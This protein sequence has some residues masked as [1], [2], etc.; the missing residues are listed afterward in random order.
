MK[1]RIGLLGGT[2]DPVHFGHLRVGEEAREALTLDR[3][4]LLPAKIPPHKTGQR[5]TPLHHR[6]AMLRLAIE[7]NALFHISEAEACRE[8]VSYLVDTLE[9][10]RTHLLPDASLYF[11]MGMDSFR[12]IA[13]WHRYGEL[14]SLSDF[15]VATRP[16]YP[17]PRLE[18]VVS[19]DV[20]ESLRPDPAGAPCLVHRSGHRV[21][22]LET[23]LLDISARKLRRGV[24]RDAS[25][26]YLLPEKVRAYILREGLYVNDG[27]E[28][29]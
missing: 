21:H 10:Y 23:T 4:E 7:G 27:E 9:A 20:A 25:V 16:G 15:V 28:E 12:E 8:G 19:R 5:L 24:R 2:F 1:K 17:F 3:I 11:I 26:R 6:L 13:T 22:F 29:R 18:D 14:F